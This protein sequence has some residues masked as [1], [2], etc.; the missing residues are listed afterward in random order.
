MFAFTC[1][2][3]FKNNL[4]LKYLRNYFIFLMLFVAKT[5]FSQVKDVRAALN[6]E[7]FYST[8][9]VSQDEQIWVESDGYTFHTQNIDSIWHK[10]KVFPTANQQKWKEGYSIGILYSNNYGLNWDTLHSSLDSV[11]LDHI[12]MK[13]A[14][15]GIAG[16][17]DNDLYST[18][19]NWHTYKKIETPK[20]QNFF[21]EDSNNDYENFEKICISDSFLFI[22]QGYRYFYTKLDN[23]KWKEFPLKIVDFEMDKTS[24]RIFAITSDL[25]AISFSDPQH[26]V[27]LSNK[28]LNHDLADL[29]VVNNTIYLADYG[30]DI[31]KINAKEFK[32]VTPLTTDC[33]IG[34]P[35]IIIQ[36][37]NILWGAKY[38][39]LY[40][41]ENKGQDWYREAIVNFD[42]I[43]FYLLSDSLAV[44]WDG[45]Q[46]N[47]VYNLKEKSCSIYEPKHAL[48]DFLKFQI[49]KFSITAEKYACFSGDANR[50]IYQKSS[51]TLMM[52]DKMEIYGDI[53]E[54]KPFEHSMSG[55]LLHHVFSEINLHPSKI[56]TSKDFKITEADKIK[57]IENIQE[58]VNDA[59][60]NYNHSYFG[61][62]YLKSKDTAFFYAIP[63]RFDT[64]SSNT[65]CFLLLKEDNV[66]ATLYNSLYF[67]F[68]NEN[69]DTLKINTNYA[70][71]GLPLFLPANI[72]FKHASFSCYDLDLANYFDACLPKDFMYGIKLSNSSFLELLGD[73]LFGKE[74]EVK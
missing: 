65:L 64:M 37:K 14:M 62:F 19:D 20:D 22:S 35:N 3:K 34:K 61:R 57:Y 25:R 15:S 24:K 41:S 8:I 45:L 69:N 54:T 9:T 71:S 16:G 29:K 10:A 21:P 28:K 43:G 52:A 30:H 17:L 68:I 27:Y 40:I 38:N 32:R 66:F 31:Y 73:Y 42:I 47:Y 58:R 33:K 12:F 11:R 60:A 70:T 7:K 63:N 26:F 55:K 6:F 36:F 67:E 56:P 39:H 50:V 51:D 23:I 44:L 5:A 53:I 48:D 74:L 1:K 49:Q 13:N 59:E 4:M 2:E 18:E 46:Y 72:T